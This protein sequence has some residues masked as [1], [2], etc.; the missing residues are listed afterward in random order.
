MIRLLA[1]LAI[2]GAA[3]IL[4]ALAGV[5]I[6]AGNAA[7]DTAV[8]EP[9]RHGESS[10]LVVI[11]HSMFNAPADMHDVRDVVAAWRPDAD[12]LMPRY[13]AGP[14]A[15]TDLRE[16]AAELDAR[17]QKL[18][19]RAALE[20][21]RYRRIVIIGHGAGALVARRAYLYGKGYRADYLPI[22]ARGRANPW[23]DNVERIVL[24]AGMNR[25]WA[26]QPSPEHA[27][28]WKRFLLRLGERIARVTGTG[29]MVLGARRGSPF[30]TNL[31]AE[32]I[33]LTR[34]HTPPPVIQLLG[35]ADGVVSAA[36]DTDQM[37]AP[38]FAFIRV[39][40][41][42]HGDLIE[43][44]DSPDMSLRRR[45]Q[46]LTEAL[47]AGIDELVARYPPDRTL[48][49]LEPDITHIVFI[50]HGVLDLGA[51]MDRF[52]RLVARDDASVEIL[53]PDYDRIPMAS[54]LLFADRQEK[55]RELA[56]EYTEALARFPH[57]DR[58]SFIGHSN[59]TFLLASLLERYAA[60]GFHR[61]YLAGSVVR[62]DFEWRRFAARVGAVRND[63]AAGDWVVAVFPRLFEQ[64]RRLPWLAGLDYL[65]PGSSGFNGFDAP[66]AEHYEFGYFAGG[67]GGALEA[68]MNV[69]SIAEFVLED[70]L[71]RMSRP[72]PLLPAAPGWLEL[73]SDFAWLVWLA[74]LVVV[75]GAGVLLW[76]VA[77]ARGTVLVVY[78]GALV[79]ALYTI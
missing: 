57:A 77:P 27:S 23:V 49:E 72:V 6:F 34:E 41:A 1:L 71:A 59:G 13:D 22:S 12:I 46:T 45:R 53:A 51:W 56:D 54:F 15:N 2:L 74:L 20:G 3:L 16:V 60:L 65:A 64:A 11:V 67:H 66:L 69:Y 5:A 24:L 32:W 9:E 44:G 8:V 14:F 31:R 79:A 7:H 19:D 10:E 35:D 28:T 39:L 73:A 55:V 61:V 17:I 58:V 30:V 40:G 47:T 52:R 70:N 43:F 76:R 18:A 78:V 26:P 29:E 75:I 36:D 4:I 68:Q 25:G 63:M 48:L 37:A 21:R 33:R 42:G 62:R 50:R 38:R